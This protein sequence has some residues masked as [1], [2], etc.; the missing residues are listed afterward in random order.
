[1][2]A[3]R[4]NII[5]ILVVLLMSS[6]FVFGLLMPGAR[7]MQNLREAIAAEQQGVAMRQAEVGDISGLYQQLVE[8]SDD[9]S[10]FR[11]RL[12][13]DRRL[14]EF[15]NNLSD[16]MSQTG[17]TDFHVQPLPATRV[18]S[19][20][21]PPRLKL[22]EGTGILPVQIGFRAD[23]QKAFEL[24]G[25]IELLPRLAYVER[26]DVEAE[27]EL[28]GRLSVTMV[29]QAFHHNHEQLIGDVPVD[30]AAKGEASRKS[31]G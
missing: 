30:L 20:D 1:M 29:V 25:A 11:E 10:T 8:L 23:F 27:D 21:L 13:A 24:L 17:I 6:G 22:A 2:N 18:S 31:N 12:P 9:V 5:T 28:T 4:L 16:A 14:G 3:N 15:L 26:L 19:E 7:Q